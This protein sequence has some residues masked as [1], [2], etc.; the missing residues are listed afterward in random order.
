MYLSPSNLADVSQSEYDLEL[1]LE[2]Y[3]PLTTKELQTL[4]EDVDNIADMELRNRARLLGNRCQEMEKIM[5]ARETHLID[6]KNE[7]WITGVNMRYE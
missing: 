4:M 5:R 6:T 7:E 2:R 1:F 3:P